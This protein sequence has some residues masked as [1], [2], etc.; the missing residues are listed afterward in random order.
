[1]VDEDLHLFAPSANRI[2]WLIK[3]KLVQVVG[4]MWSLGEELNDILNKV[5]A[6]LERPLQEKFSLSQELRE[7]I[8]EYVK[9]RLKESWQ[10][11]EKSAN[12]AEAMRMASPVMT[13]RKEELERMVNVCLFE[14]RDRFDQIVQRANDKKPTQDPVL[15]INFNDIKKILDNARASYN[16][17]FFDK[18]AF[19]QHYIS[20][21]REEL[22]EKDREMANTMVAILREGWQQKETEWALRLSSKSGSSA[23]LSMHPQTAIPQK[24]KGPTLQEVRALEVKAAQKALENAQ[25]A[26]REAQ[27]MVNRLTP[28]E[29]PAPVVSVGGTVTSKK[30]PPPPPPLPPVSSRK[31]SSPS[32][33][34]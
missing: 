19:E 11:I 18:A 33:S 5:D 9:N 17:S 3:E 25:K 29:T 16:Q 27:A 10:H 30:T 23:P 31:D 8:R 14:D 28:P 13:L 12:E 15:K 1:M 34:K 21:I 2:L 4:E 22:N 32:T 24:S 26:L 6:K 7:Y 20:I